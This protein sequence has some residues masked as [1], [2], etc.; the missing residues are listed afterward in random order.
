MRPTIT[1]LAA[2]LAACLAS[3]VAGVTGGAA[4]TNVFVSGATGAVY[5][6]AHPVLCSDLM[7][8]AGLGR[9]VTVN[10]PLVYARALQNGS[11]W[12]YVHY[13]AEITDLATGI[14]RPLG[15]SAWVTPSTSAARWL[16]QL[17]MVGLPAGHRMVVRMMVEW[18]DPVSGGY[19]GALSYTVDRYNDLNYGPDYQ[20]AAY[21]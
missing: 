20:R 8:L 6:D 3:L 1:T 7:A 12:Q 17:K 2:V 14:T 16:P 18:W 5:E 4:A 9:V 11:T 15:P 13:R 10:G 19:T 21:C